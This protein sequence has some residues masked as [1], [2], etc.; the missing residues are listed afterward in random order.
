[1][2]YLVASCSPSQPLIRIALETLLT[3]GYEPSRTIFLVSGF[4]EEV[5]GPRVR[6]NLNSTFAANPTDC[7]QGAKFISEYLLSTYGED[8]FALLVDEGGEQFQCLSCKIISIFQGDNRSSSGPVLPFQPL[9]RK[10]TRTHRSPSPALVVTQ[11]CLLNI[12][13]LVCSL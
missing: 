10:V 4:D 2:P 5:S 3:H 9:V 11:A 8:Y 6:L 7:L 1:M 13:L 12:H